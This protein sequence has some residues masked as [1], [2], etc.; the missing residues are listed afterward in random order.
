M[1]KNYVQRVRIGGSDRHWRRTSQKFDFYDIK[2][3]IL[4]CMQLFKLSE[5][6]IEISNTIPKWYHPGQSASF[7]KKDKSLLASFGALHPEVLSE[8]DLKD[9]V[10]GFELYI[11]S[12]TDLVAEKKKQDSNLTLSP[13]QSVDRDFAF[14]VDQKVTS[15]EIMNLVKNVDTQLIDNVKV[16]D[17]YQGGEIP[18]GKK[19]YAISVCLQPTDKTLTEEEINQLSEKI[20][21]KIKKEIGAVLRD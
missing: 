12:L 8:F 2:A 13:L 9:T 16:F 19:S 18:Q 4:S 20:V 6:N 21:L 11:D 1:D 14:I 7:H 17:I 15:K 3:D 5:E 10:I